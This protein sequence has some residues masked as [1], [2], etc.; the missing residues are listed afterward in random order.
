MATVAVMHQLGIYQ[1]VFNMI[2]S[3]ELGSVEK[4]SANNGS[5]NSLVETLDAP[6]LVDIF[7][8]PS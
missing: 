6:V 4:D 2:I 8:V 3:S 5:L 1:G 7:D